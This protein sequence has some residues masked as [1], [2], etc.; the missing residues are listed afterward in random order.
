MLS[1][2]L[3][4]LWYEGRNDWDAA[5]EIAQSTNSPV[6]CWIHAYLHRKEGD[7]WNTNYWYTRAGRTMPRTSL[8]E[9]W[10]SMVKELLAENK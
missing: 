1:K 2:P 5:H 7:T 8:A 10:E 3:Q 6:N 4:A 9:E